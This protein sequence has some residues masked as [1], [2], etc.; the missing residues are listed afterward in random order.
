[1]ISTLTYLPYHK[2][3]EPLKK[4]DDGGNKNG[5]LLTL[6]FIEK[7][8]ELIQKDLE[9]FTIMKQEVEQLLAKA[10]HRSKFN[11]VDNKGDKKI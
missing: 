4:S 6:Q 8:L 2:M 7:R 9:L 1:M 5:E 11:V 10:G 3:F